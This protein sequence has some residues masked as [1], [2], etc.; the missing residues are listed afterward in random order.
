MVKMK[1]SQVAVLCAALGVG[2]AQAAVELPALKIDKTQTTVSGLSSGGYMAVQMH[3]AFSSTF[4]KGAGVIAGG[5][6]YCA[7]GSVSTATG[8][9]M[10]TPSSINVDTL[11]STTNSW[12]SQG[13][14]D[15]TSN[16]GQS[17]VYLFSGSLDTTVVPGVMDA[18]QRYYLKYVPTANIQY[19]KDIAAEHSMVSDDYGNA[20]NVKA[21]PYINDCDYDLPGAMFTQLYG[22]LNARNNGTL[23]GS[24]IEFNQSTFVSGHGMNGTGWA[25]VPQECTGGTSC[26]LHV[27][28]H[29][30]KQNPSYIGDEYVRKAGYNRWADTNRIVVLYPQTGSGA[31]NGC[32]D[33]WGYDSANYAK[34][35]GPQMAAV[36]AMVD[37]VSSGDGS[38]TPD[39]LPAPTNVTASGA[40]AS[41]MVISWGSVTGAASY[42][43]Y[44]NGTKV[45][46]SAITGTSY[47]DSGLAAGT[48][49]TWTV[50]A[51]SSAGAEGTA[52]SGVSAS[53]TGSSATC[54]TASNYSHTVAGRAYAAWGL[55]YAKGSNDSMGWWNIYTTTTLKQTSPGYYVVGTCQ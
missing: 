2:L 36:K 5:P 31:T 52:S 37:K 29:G 41:S 8:A 12:A 24:F 25:Y 3:V 49:Y 27:A 11:A 50:R 48:T 16:L 40:T 18:L 44:R 32:W 47:T 14:I 13:L 15:A 1:V 46:T 38:T 54:Y 7:Q 51:V 17:Q 55:T 26:R 20:C 35:S 6:F 19:K 43:V 9:C 30:C 10:S 39:A 42:N 21:S 33:W 53:T 23:S 45:N 4:A 34:K 22:T 28:F